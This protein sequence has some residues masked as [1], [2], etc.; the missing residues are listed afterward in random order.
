[1]RDTEF[2]EGGQRIFPALSV[3]RQRPLVF[4]VEVHLRKGKALGSEKGK[5]WDV[6]FVV[7]RENRAG[8]LLRTIGNNFDINIGRA[9]L[10]LNFDLT[11]GGRDFD[12]IIE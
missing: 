3:S 2:S 5:G 4:L 1:V 10:N 11:L 6:E 12:V 7:N 9:A 8:D